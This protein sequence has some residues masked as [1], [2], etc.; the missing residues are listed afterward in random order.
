[1]NNLKSSE[2]KILET[3]FQ[4]EGG[5]V[6]DF[7]DNS[8]E[9]FF[10]EDFNIELYNEKYDL[11]FPSRSKANRLRG[12]WVVEEKNMVGD[13]ILSLID[14]AEANILTN[15]KKEISTAEQNLIVKARE[16]G[17]RL[18]DT[19]TIK[20]LK[21][22]SGLIKSFNSFDFTKL[23]T[24]KKIYILKVLFSY[25]EAILRTYYGSGMFFITSG[26]DD[27]NDYFK[28]LR[29]KIME[30]IDTDETFSEI[31]QNDNHKEF[32]KLIGSLYT[33]AEFLDVIWHDSTIPVIISLRE[34]IAD[35]D[36][37][38][39]GSEIHKVDLVVVNLLDEIS[40]EIE[41]LKKIIKEKT[42]G[43]YQNDLSIRQKR[44]NDNTSDKDPIKHEHTHHFENNIQEKPIDLIFG[45]IKTKEPKTKPKFPFTIQSGTTWESIYIQFKNAEAVIIQVSGHTHDTSFADMGFADHRTH[46]PNMQ[47]GLLIALAKNGGSLSAGDPDA[48]DKY[49]KHKQLLADNLKSYFSIDFDPFKP[50]DKEDGYVLKLSASYPRLNEEPKQSPDMSEE[51]S[52]MFQNLDE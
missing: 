1:M 41:Q 7:S 42:E 31:S 43:F 20:N 30:I 24:G 2:R 37:F 11:D 16:I 21:N 25:Y 49:K 10:K 5:Y 6:L 22:K 36:L 34:D 27:L 40:K 46:K 33:S 13:I 47:W 35:K 12:I 19:G 32:F 17:N 28:V 51:I 15:S 39:N 26:I 52:E 18:L 9:R 8:M 44:A 14:C 4:M 45:E 29:K 48:N 38:E 3:L 50:Y 23:E